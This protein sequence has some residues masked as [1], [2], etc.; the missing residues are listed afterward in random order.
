LDV[1]F[2]SIVGS[3]PQSREDGDPLTHEAAKYVI[4]EKIFGS[5][6]ERVKWGMNL[7]LEKMGM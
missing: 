3:P 2:L 1:F 6:L 5:N 7:L 4:R